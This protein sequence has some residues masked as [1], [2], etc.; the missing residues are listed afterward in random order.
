ME[1][2]EGQEVHKGWGL[3]GLACT[4]WDKMG[5]FGSVVDGVTA[6]WDGW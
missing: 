1:A 3:L 4:A 6:D 5:C 2:G